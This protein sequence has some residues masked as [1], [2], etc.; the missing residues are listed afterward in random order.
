MYHE[1][2]RCM[3]ILFYTN[4]LDNIKNNRVILEKIVCT[5]KYLHWNPVVSVIL[6][7]IYIIFIYKL[8][9]WNFDVESMAN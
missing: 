2:T 3:G 8:S 9:M 7:K 4:K 6:K 1:S 5:C